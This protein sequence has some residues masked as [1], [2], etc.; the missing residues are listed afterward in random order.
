[1]KPVFHPVCPK[2][3]DETWILQHLSYYMN[4]AFIY[5]SKK[6][7]N[8]IENKVKQVYAFSFYIRLLFFPKV[9]E[10]RVI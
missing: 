1:M 5:F 10:P 6:D 4:N 9:T 3:R 7:S 8:T 2:W